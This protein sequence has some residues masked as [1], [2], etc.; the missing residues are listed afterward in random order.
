M[1]TLAT[2]AK[3]SMV[4]VLVLLCVVLAHVS[5]A[6]ADEGDQ[7]WG[8]SFTSSSAIHV[9]RAIAVDAQGDVIVTG[10]IA[11]TVD[12][13]GG[14]IAA[15]ADGSADAF[16]AKYD[17][18]GN[19]LWSQRFGER[20]PQQANGV[21][22]DD[23]GN[24]F[25]TGEFQGTIDFG[26]DALVGTGNWDIFL[27]KFDPNGNHLWSQT[28]TE[29]STGYTSAQTANA[30]AADADGNVVITGEFSRSVDFGGA[31][32]ENARSGASDIYVAKF[33]GD[34]N[35]LWSRGFGDGSPQYANSLAVGGDGSIVV[36]GS[37]D[38]VLD[39]GGASLSSAGRYD[40]YLGKLSADGGHVWSQ[41]FGDERNGQE[42]K[43]VAIDGDG[44]IGITGYFR[45][46]MDLGGGPLMSESGDIFVAE[47]DGAGQHLWSKR[48]GSE[49]ITQ[50]GSTLTTDTE[51]NVAVAGY[52]NGIINLGGED[53]GRGG[54]GMF[55][56]QFDSEGN[57]LWSKVAGG[58]PYGIAMHPGGSV[59]VTGTVVSGA[60]FAGE[61]FAFNGL[62]LA[63]LEGAQTAPPVVPPQATDVERPSIVQSVPDP[64]EISTDPGVVGTNVTLAVV[65]VIV[66]L[67][68]A[69]VFNGTIEENNEEIERFARR[70]VR[71]VAAPLRGARSVWRRVGLINPHISRI[72]GIGVVLGA[73]ALV[74]GFLEPGFQLNEDGIL[75]LISVV[76]ALGITTYAYSGTEARLAERR[77]NV[78]AAVR[79][80]PVACSIAVVSVVVSR[81]ISFQPGIVY[82]FV[83]SAVVLGELQVRQRGLAVFGAATCLLGVFGLAWLAMVPARSWAEHDG[84]V[85]SVVLESSTTLVVVSAIQG[86]AFNMLPVAFMPGHKMWRANRFGWFV[87]AVVTVGFFLHVLVVQNEAGFSAISEHGT[88]GLLVA[89]GVC[90]GLTASVWGLF[91]YRRHGA[92]TA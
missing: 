10:T 60:D 90:V 21:A 14:P 72:V 5:S 30:V 4:L 76:V 87:L 56:G 25:I 50:Y 31:V 67:L 28:F 18:A 57:H 26:G 84:N 44:N 74:Y 66:I 48:F 70:Y 20:S 51:G 35:H 29:A 82:G 6:H 71:P 52:F 49:T 89:L 59:M 11:G 81:L 73:T 63:K 1:K 86:L 85:L 78:P 55:V 32:L 33:D 15:N 12:L 45:G 3:F 37:F 65:V 40:I 53:L 41:R 69:Q 54:Y 27:A 34:G 13:G 9:G 24:I 88:V 7:E 39:F 47:F 23:A 68:S 19:Y 83:A 92:T 79:V 42:A 38:G 61:Q 64:T 91:V 43:D 80:Y 2:T 46:T 8:Q 58:E 17:A 16:V 77:F 75:L 62:F 22:V 36:T